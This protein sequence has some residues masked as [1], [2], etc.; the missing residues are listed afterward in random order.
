MLP[1]A[2]FGHALVNGQ[3]QI[4]LPA[5]SLFVGA[6]LSA[7]HGMLLLFIF[8]FQSGKT[9]LPAQF[10][11]SMPQSVQTVQIAVVLFAG[12]EAYR[13]DNKMGMDML[14]V[15][16]GC[17]HNFKTGN[18]L[19]Q[20]QRNLMCLL[21]CDGIARME[22]LHHVVIHSSFHTFVLPFCVQELLQGSLRY[23]V[24]TGDQGAALAGN[25]FFPTAVAEDTVETTHGL[26]LLTLYKVNDCHITTASV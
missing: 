19:R 1:A 3:L 4:Q 18:L 6:V 14:P 2:C 11:G 16:M 24:H 10:I 13:V 22:G 21:R 20:L 15:G 12:L 17:N 26:G 9:V 8:R 25:L 23:T 7:G 5:L